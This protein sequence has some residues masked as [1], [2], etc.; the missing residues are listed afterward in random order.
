MVK[1][2]ILE[3]HIQTRKQTI[4]KN[5]KEEIKFIADVIELVKR[6]NTSHI[7]SKEDLESIIQESAHS[8]DDIYIVDLKP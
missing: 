8:M 6:L 1:I 3:E 4:I 2:L 7:S 5:S